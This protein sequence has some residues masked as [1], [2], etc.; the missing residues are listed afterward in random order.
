MI[1]VEA[2]TVGAKSWWEIFSSPEDEP[3][4]NVNMD[5]SINCVT[6]FHCHKLLLHVHQWQSF[7]WWCC[8]F[9]SSHIRA[10]TICWFW[11]SEDADRWNAVSSCLSAWR[12][13]GCSVTVLGLKQLFQLLFTLEFRA[14]V[15][16]YLSFKEVSFLCG[17]I[18]KSQRIQR[19]K[20]AVRIII[21]LDSSIC[22]QIWGS[23]L[24]IPP[25]PLGTSK[26]L[27]FQLH[28]LRPDRTITYLL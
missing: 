2:G 8:C 5:F 18:C 28:T 24:F 21:M 10:Q 20:R 26:L 13:R 3:G 15:S 16:H 27:E 17:K 25:F 7:Q 14:C 19:W 1:N 4:Y 11:R 22:A 12:Q 9:S 6:L 23:L